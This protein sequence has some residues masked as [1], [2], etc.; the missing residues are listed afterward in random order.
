MFLLFWCSS[1]PR[2]D[3]VSDLSRWFL[4]LCNILSSFYLFLSAFLFSGT[5]KKKSSRSILYLPWEMS[6]FSNDSWFLF[7]DFPLVTLALDTLIATGM[8][9]YLCLFIVELRNILQ[10]RNPAF[11]LAFTVPIQLHRVLPH[12]SLFNIETSLFHI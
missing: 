10:I 2:F 6:H 9:L 12:I 11:I 7:N 4:Y 1:C 8:S 3:P 5:K